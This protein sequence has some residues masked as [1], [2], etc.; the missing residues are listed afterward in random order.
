MT[1]E[2]YMYSS[3]PSLISALNGVGGQRHALAAFPMGKT[4]ATHW[5]EGWAGS[6]T[7][8]GNLVPTGIRSPDRPVSS[9]SI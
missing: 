5:K 4:H 8:A 1:E 3:I 9:K 7:G 6:R 2:K